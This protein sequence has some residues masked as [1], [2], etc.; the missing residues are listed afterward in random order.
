MI[1]LNNLDKETQ[2][3]LTL[4]EEYEPSFSNALEVDY[5]DVCFA[6]LDERRDPNIQHSY[7]ASLH[8][9]QGSGK[10]YAGL[11]L[12]GYLDPKFSIDKIYFDY[13][14]LVYERSKLK[15]NTCVLIDEQSRQFGVDSQRIVTVLNALK[16]QLRKKS[17]HM[18][19]C[20]PT[21]KDEYA[22]SMYVLETMFIDKAFKEAYFAYKTNDLR[23]LGYV[24]L[25][26]PLKSI[27]KQLLLDYEG[28]K[29]EHLEELTEKPHDEVEERAVKITNNDYFKRI[30]AMYVAKKG[31]IPS[32]ILVQI[33]NKIYP[34]FKSSVIVF[35]LADR[36]RLNKESSNEWNI[37]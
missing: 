6:T 28:V 33:I 3:R 5:T 29:D 9:M 19:Y 16:E 31:Y 30:E 37:T 7:L 36:I 10:S 26:H 34:E 21:L 12:A 11:F 17:I 4:K 35:E 20:S 24:V 2:D 18:I 1:D 27:S 14:K 25:S 13:N 22:T 23:C 32:K 8:G 15:P